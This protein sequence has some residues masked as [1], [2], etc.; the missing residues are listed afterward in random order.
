MGKFD[1]KILLELGTNICSVE[2]V[3]YA[4]S[5]GA[6][7][8]VADY[9]PANSSEAKKVA[10]EYVQISTADIDGLCELV[11]QRGIQGVFCGVS[12]FNLLSVLEIANRMGLPCYFT[13]EQW[14]SLQNKSDFKRNCADNRI[15]IPESYT[16]DSANIQY[17]VIVK[18]SE[19]S[20]SRGVVICENLDELKLAI[21]QAERISADHTCIIEQYL[22]LDEVM[23]YYV[24]SE[25]MIRLSAMCDRYMK[26]VDRNSPQL[27]VGY[28]YPSKY[29]GV[30]EEKFDSSVREFIKALGINNGLLAFQAFL[31]NDSF[32]PFDPT[33]RL[34]GTTAYH[35]TERVNKANVLKELVDYAILGRFT[36]SKEWLK[37]ENPHFSKVCFEY[38]LLLS[39]GTIARVEG[40]NKVA[41][42]KSVIHINQIKSV[43]DTL[44]DNA[45]FTQ[46]FC[47]I[48]LCCETKDELLEAVDF[49]QK[50]LRVFSSDNRNMNIDVPELRERIME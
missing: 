1:G 33:Y 2:I 6:Y 15:S 7:V 18:P 39:K 27:P 26:R 45:A 48:L 32:I 21:Q 28:Y 34:D 36:D 24:I 3:Q 9:L 30:Y 31:S 11:K 12:E 35:F 13:S 40:L 41:D 23:V 38:P 29:L 25:G 17:P 49:I 19:G 5:E 42:L 44:E 20:A 4:R 37:R 22:Q 10:N 14:K 47:R 50:N 43:G 8:I 16:R 46:I